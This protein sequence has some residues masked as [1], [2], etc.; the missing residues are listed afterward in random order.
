MR[1]AVHALGLS[2][3]GVAIAGGLAACHISGTY[4]PKAVLSYGT[5]IPVALRPP[6]GFTRDTAPKAAWGAS[7]RLV[8]VIWGSGSCPTLP[9]HVSAKGT[10]QIVISTVDYQHGGDACTSDLRPTASIVAVPR[11]IDDR[12]DVD[13]MID[14]TTV[15]LGPRTAA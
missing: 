13:V 10:H 8:L 15:R 4:V 5:N 12:H 6:S 2:L 11:G 14:K 3:A 7:G 9:E 1:R